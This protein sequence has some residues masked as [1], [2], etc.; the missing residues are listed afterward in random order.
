MTAPIFADVFADQWDN[1]PPVMKA[2]YA[3]RPFSH[4][5]VTVEGRLDVHIHPLM[6]PFAP[7]MAALGLLAPWAG[8]D[9]PCTVQF[10][11]Q[12]D[13]NAFIFN[14]QFRFPGRKSYPFRSELVA[15]G[16]HDVVEYMRCGIGW[17]C[18]Y[19][20]DGGRVVLAHK[21]YVV[22]LFGRDVP[23]PGAGLIVGR[24]EAFEEATSDASFSMFMALNHPLFGRL[25]SYGG[26]FTVTETALA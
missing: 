19:S 23:L 6:K 4:D 7:L 5:R 12:A 11:S 24:G 14:R 15:K 8:E 25:Y 3:N 13:G 26:T 18:G 17:R 1:L 16:P 10:L 20:F 9:V 22:R 21:G 2:H